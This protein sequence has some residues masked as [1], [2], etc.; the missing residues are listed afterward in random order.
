M[1]IVQTFKYKQSLR[2]LIELHLSYQKN[3]RFKFKN[4]NVLSVLSFFDDLEIILPT[5]I[6]AH[7]GIIAINEKKVIETFTRNLKPLGI[8]T[9]AS[10]QT[11]KTAEYYGVIRQLALFFDSG[12]HCLE[13]FSRLLV[14]WYWLDDSYRTS[15]F[16][17]VMSILKKRPSDGDP[18]IELIKT[19]DFQDWFDQVDLF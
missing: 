9:I 16:S 1:V 4:K 11:Q 18:F 15:N 5:F 2:E 8:G 17:K 19:K 14:K 12:K 6:Q 7:G 10:I 3:N 13:I